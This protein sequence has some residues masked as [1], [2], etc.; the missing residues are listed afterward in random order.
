[1]GSSLFYIHRQ[2]ARGDNQ[3]SL[4]YVMD[5][6]TQSNTFSTLGHS[7]GYPQSESHRIFSHGRERIFGDPPDWLKEVLSDDINV[8]KTDQF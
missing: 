3:T 5:Q 8:E 2:V 4:T 7:F 6:T 1:M